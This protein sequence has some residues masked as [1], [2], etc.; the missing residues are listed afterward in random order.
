MPEDG[1]RYEL[2]DGGVFVVPASLPRHQIVQTL[3]L[4]TLRGC[5]RAHGDPQSERIEIC[6]LTDGVRALRT[7]ATAGAE[8][9]S[10]ILAGHTFSARSVFP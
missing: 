2:Y 10:P 5:A 3:L 6:E 1:C 4:D 8:V 7:G 9:R